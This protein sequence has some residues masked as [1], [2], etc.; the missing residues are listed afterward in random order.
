MTTK[1]KLHMMQEI[2]KRNEK[3][4]AEYLGKTSGK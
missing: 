2:E 3:R 4:L 1:D